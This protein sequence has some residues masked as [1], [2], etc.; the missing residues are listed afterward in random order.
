LNPFGI[1]SDQYDTEADKL[2]VDFS[3][4]ISTTLSTSSEGE[5]DHSSIVED[6]GKASAVQ[7]SPSPPRDER[8]GIK[9]NLLSDF[10]AKA[11]ETGESNPS[12]SLK[13]LQRVNLHV[14][15]DPHADDRLSD[16]QLTV[17][18]LSNDPLADDCLS[19]VQLAVDCS[20]DDCFSAAINGPI[21]EPVTSSIEPT[22]APIEPTTA[23]IKPMMRSRLDSSPIE[24]TTASIKPM[25]R[26]Q[27]D[28]SP[29]EQMAPIEPTTPPPIEPTWLP[30]SLRRLALSR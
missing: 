10:D 22:M 19:D 20:T 13:M 9:V 6:F 18:R 27:L 12:D 23:S 30:S 11:M 5:R 1:V 16:N 15:N 2:R 24:P 3:N 29:I 25:M 8:V 4:D 17:D 21:I 7:S 28:S 14:S 26:S